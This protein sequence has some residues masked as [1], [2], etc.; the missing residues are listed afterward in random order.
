M[1]KSTV[2]VT[3]RMSQNLF[4]RFKER[5]GEDN[6]SLSGE[7]AFMIAYYLNN[8]REIPAYYTISYQNVQPHDPER[9]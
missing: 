9:E 5:A 1:V 7:A 3:V 6:R 4:D 2:S 8:I